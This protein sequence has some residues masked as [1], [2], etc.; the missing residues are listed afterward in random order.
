M[1]FNLVPKTS[2]TYRGTDNAY[3]GY[4]YGDINSTNY[5]STHQNKN[6]SQAKEKVDEWYEKT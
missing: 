4:M 5:E 1:G 6:D 2:W 3:V